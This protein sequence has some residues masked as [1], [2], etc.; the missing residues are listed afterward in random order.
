MLGDRVG[1][2]RY[3]PHG[4][5][6]GHECQEPDGPHPHHRFRPRPKRPHTQAQEC[7]LEY[8]VGKI[9]H[10]PHFYGKPPNQ[11]QLLKENDEGDARELHTVATYG[12]ILCL[13]PEPPVGGGASPRGRGAACSE[14]ALAMKH[15]T[16]CEK[17][18]AFFAPPRVCSQTGRRAA[19]S[20]MSALVSLGAP[21]W[22]ALRRVVMPPPPV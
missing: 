9:P 10:H 18:K 21:R 13:D 11:R 20:R 15:G 2:K 6:A 17:A 3:S 12:Q 5:G 7:T 19:A 16:W 8:Q 4:P 22:S 14:A 1:R